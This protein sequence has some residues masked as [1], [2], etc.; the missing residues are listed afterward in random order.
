MRNHLLEL[1]G[2]FADE[3]VEFVVCGGVA[4]VL[5]GCDRTTFDIDLAVRLTRENL[6]RCIVA[7][8]RSR[9][10]PRIPEPIEH[11]LD[12]QIRRRWVTEKNALVYT[13]LDSDSLLQVDIFL[14]YPIDFDDLRSD[15]DRFDIDSVR[16]LVSSKRHLIAAKKTVKPAR[17]KDI[18]DIRALQELIDGDR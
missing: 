4:C 16:F 10:S 8:R 13:L 3:H 12:D 18:A 7:A 11:L 14:K 5:Q 2:T 9:L 6:E 15:A 1:I 17:E